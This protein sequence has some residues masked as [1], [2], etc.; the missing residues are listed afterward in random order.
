MSRTCV[1][2]TAKSQ[3]FN[4]SVD[5]RL[6]QYRDWSEHTPTETCSGL[7]VQNIIG[8][9]QQYEQNMVVLAYYFSAVKTTRIYTAIDF[10]T[11]TCLHCKC[12][13]KLSLCT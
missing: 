6:L 11:M 12:L 8:H 5:P 9:L 7:N 1:Y 2:Q 10:V 13:T 4:L 3:I